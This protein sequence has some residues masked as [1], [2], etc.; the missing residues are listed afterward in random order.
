MPIAPILPT[1]SSSPTLCNDEERNKVIGELVS[2]EETYVKDLQ[3][4]VE[5]F[6]EPLEQR[7]L[8]SPT[9]VKRLFWNIGS[10]Y[11][12]H[13]NVLSKLNA[14]LQTG[15][16]HPRQTILLNNIFPVEEN[17]WKNAY[18]EY[19]HNLSESMKFLDSIKKKSNIQMFLKVIFLFFLTQLFL[20]NS[21]LIILG[22]K[23]RSNVQIFRIN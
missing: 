15:K 4:V 19:C 7:N 12:L 11:K 22:S 10:I 21:F 16:Q 3:V 6:Q 20:R 2:T 23:R 13:T 9:E 8:L 14:N 18:I 1:T 17:A 5:K